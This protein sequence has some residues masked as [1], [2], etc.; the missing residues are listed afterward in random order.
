MRAFTAGLKPTSAC[1]LQIRV[2]EDDS[3]CPRPELSMSDRERCAQIPANCSIR[4]CVSTGVCRTTTAPSARRGWTP[5]RQANCLARSIGGPSRSVAA[6][7]SH[8]GCCSAGSIGT[9]KPARSSPRPWLP[10]ADCSGIPSPGSS[11]NNAAKSDPEPHRFGRKQL[12]W[13]PPRATTVLR[14]RRWSPRTGER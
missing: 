14:C 8:R 4:F 3:I 10:R 11:A 1:S 2:Q 7:H 9:C 13:R 5:R 12:H 6:F